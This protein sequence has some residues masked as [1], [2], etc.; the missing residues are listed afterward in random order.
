[1]KTVSIKI[2]DVYTV[3]FIDEEGSGRF[4]STRNGVFHKDLV[5][6]SL[7]LGMF[8]KIESLTEENRI[9]KINRVPFGETQSV[10]RLFE[11]RKE[12]I[13]IS[14]KCKHGETKTG[15]CTKEDCP[16]FNK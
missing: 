15:L 7:A 5:P 3:H 16:L 1:M 13:D 12:V 14:P 11:I 6:D 4:Y 2:D 10:C 8:S 9:L